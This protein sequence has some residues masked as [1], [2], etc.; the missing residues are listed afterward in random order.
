MAPILPEWRRAT[1]PLRM[2][3]RVFAVS[4]LPHVVGGGDTVKPLRGDVPNKKRARRGADTKAVC[5]AIST[6]QETTCV[7]QFNMES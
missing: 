1:A 5:V 6:L 4:G 3:A 2:R 7:V